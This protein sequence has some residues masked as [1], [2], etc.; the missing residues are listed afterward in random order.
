MVGELVRLGKKKMKPK[1]YYFKLD[2]HNRLYYFRKSADQT[3]KGI[4]DMNENIHINLKSIK[5]KEQTHITIQIL[6]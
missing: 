1:V 6:K 2:T 5:I 3:P 4:L